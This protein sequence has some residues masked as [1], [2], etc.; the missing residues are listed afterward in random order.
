M[1]SETPS[2]YLKFRPWL[3]VIAAFLLLIAAWSSLIFIAV[4]HAPETITVQSSNSGH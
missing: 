4:K 3:F 1:N 2:T